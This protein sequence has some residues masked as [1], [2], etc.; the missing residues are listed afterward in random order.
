MRA[1]HSECVVVWGCGSRVHPWRERRLWQERLSPL[2]RPESGAGGLRRREEK[3]ERDVSWRPEVDEVWLG[4]RVSSLVLGSGSDRPAAALGRLTQIAG[5]KG[6]R[7]PSQG[8]A[9]TQNGRAHKP[10]AKT[11]L[12]ENGSANCDVTICFFLFTFPSTDHGPE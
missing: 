3:E 2:K 6:V 12:S 5:G 9:C 8:S 7:V 4:G 10:N 11:V 1:H